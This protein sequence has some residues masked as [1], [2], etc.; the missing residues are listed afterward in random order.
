MLPRLAILAMVLLTGCSDDAPETSADPT[1]VDADGYFTPDEEERI[2]T[3]CVEAGT[4]GVGQSKCEQFFGTVRFL[5]ASLGCTV[6]EAQELLVAVSQAR[7]DEVL[8]G[9]ECAER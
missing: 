9:L 3:A 4:P 5:S 8:A 7:Q 2:I 1:I 6:E